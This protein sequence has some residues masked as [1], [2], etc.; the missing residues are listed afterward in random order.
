[1]KRVLWFSNNA[2]P[3]VSTAGQT[4]RYMGQGWVGALESAIG[5]NPDFQLALAF[6]EK[7]ISTMKK[8]MVNNRIIYQIPYPNSKLERWKIRFLNKME[9]E[10]YIKRYLEVVDDFQPDLIHIYGTENAFGEIIN[11]VKSPVV[12]DLQGVLTGILPKWFSF[13]TPKEAYKASS[14]WSKINI[15]THY[16]YYKSRFKR[17]EREQRILSQSRFLIGRTRWDRLQM[18]VL[19]PKASYYYVNRVIREP[20]WK[21]TWT[22]DTASPLKFL[23][24]MNP[25][26]YKGF[27]V[28]LETANHLK[29]LGFDF[30]WNIAGMT[31]DNDMVRIAETKKKLKA[32]KLNI[33]FLGKQKADEIASIL[34]QTSFFVHPSYID[35]SPNSVSE[36]MVVGTPVIATNVGGIPGMIIDHETG[37]LFQ[38]G[39]AR[40]LAGLI[41]DLV[42]QPEMVA[43]VAGAGQQ[44]ARHRHHPQTVVPQLLAAYRDIF[45]QIDNQN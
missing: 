33:R 25:D 17:V 42:S 19:A 45:K 1:M 7:T 4:P 10:N 8:V 36:A 3:L 44:V 2:I 35:N 13:I 5:D 16:H 24:V 23:S 22:K 40:M 39:D 29:V 37:W 38:E 31:H 27:D 6:P 32:E 34:T 21:V 41:I 20:F 9:D 26:F 12:V 11:R 30:E 43:N 14:F 28:I 15:N 18:K